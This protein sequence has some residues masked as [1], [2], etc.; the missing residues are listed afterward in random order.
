L[1]WKGNSVEIFDVLLLDQ[2]VV[3]LETDTRWDFGL[4]GED[5]FEWHDEV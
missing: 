5:I 2:G 1:F 4:T 3:E